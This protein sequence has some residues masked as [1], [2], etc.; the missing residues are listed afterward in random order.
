MVNAG[1]HE[2]R[3]WPDSW[4]VETIDGALSAQFENTCHI[5]DDADAYMRESG[6]FLPCEVFTSMSTPY[7][8]APFFMRQLRE[9]GIEVPKSRLPEMG[10]PEP[11]F[12]CPPPPKKQ[13]DNDGNDE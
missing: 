7:L 2:H 1:R 13:D 5:V 8:D 3:M 10:L 6:S 12:G 4:T 9:Y 11:F